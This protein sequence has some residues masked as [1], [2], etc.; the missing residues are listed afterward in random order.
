M[1]I[2]IEIKRTGQAI[3]IQE[4][5]DLGTAKTVSENLRNADN[6]ESVYILRERSQPGIGKLEIRPIKDIKSGTSVFKSD[7]TAGVVVHTWATFG[8]RI[9]TRIIWDGQGEINQDYKSNKTFGVDAV[10]YAKNLA[11][12]EI[13]QENELIAERMEERASRIGLASSYFRDREKNVE[14]EALDVKSPGLRLKRIEE[15]NEKLQ[16]TKKLRAWFHEN[17]YCQGLRS[18]KSAL[19]VYSTF[20]DAIRRIEDGI[21]ALEPIDETKFNDWGKYIAEAAD[22]VDK[23]TEK[24]YFK[25]S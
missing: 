10:D 1:K 20:D 17:Q 12:W 24:H 8:D 23:W 6:V 2:K 22:E 7:G 13:E 5:N 18:V 9:G 4:F 15:L 3:E 16:E 14:L 19:Y 25:K 21:S 11:T